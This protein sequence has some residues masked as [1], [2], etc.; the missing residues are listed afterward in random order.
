MKTI[1]QLQEIRERLRATI[2]ERKE[3]AAVTPGQPRMYVL[4]CGGT[5]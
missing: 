4:V 1:E 3:G 5:G 2:E